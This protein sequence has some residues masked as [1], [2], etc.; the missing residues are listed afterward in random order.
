MLRDEFSIVE[1]LK[2]ERTQMGRVIIYCQKQEI[3]AEL[4]TFF[5]YSLGDAFLYPTDALD[6]PKYRLVDMYVSCTEPS[7]KD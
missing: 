6:L 2:A 4:Y 5:K 1:Q 7:I 3:C